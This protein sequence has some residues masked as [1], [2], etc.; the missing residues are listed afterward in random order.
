[1]T[2]FE[3]R[4]IRGITVGIIQ[5]FIVG[6]VCVCGTVIGGAMYIKGTF[7][8]HEA[9]IS[10]VEEKVENVDTKVTRLENIAMRGT[11]NGK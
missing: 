6:T 10:T 8:D 4:E 5:T 11:V 2:D 1:M 3:R 9:R 7:A